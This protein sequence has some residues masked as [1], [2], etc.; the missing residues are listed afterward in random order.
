VVVS[1]YVPSEEQA[2]NVLVVGAMAVDAKGQ[3]DQ[4]LVPGRS[5]PGA[6]HFAIGGV[7]R[8]IAET[9]ARLGVHTTLLS[10]IGNDPIGRLLFDSTVKSGVD[11]SCVVTSTKHRTGGYIAILDRN[12]IP[13]HAIAHMSVMQEITPGLVYR[14]RRLVRDADMIVLDGNLSP[15]TLAS[16]FDLANKYRCP[17]CVDPTS[18][19]LAP[20][21]IPHLSDILLM[22][23]NASE[24]EALTGLELGPSD[25][26]DLA[27]ALVGS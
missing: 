22:T 4:E 12:G 6:V 25:A 11:T 23:P 9:L 14:N 26:H 18:A 8:N 19:V 3:P 24:A 2:L 1:I 16:I 10:A 7:G 21:F 17:V 13:A 15:R 20:R 5:T 27:A